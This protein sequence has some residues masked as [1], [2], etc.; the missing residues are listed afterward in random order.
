MTPLDPQKKHQY[1]QNYY[2]KHG[3]VFLS[4]DTANIERELMNYYR[5][6]KQDRNY[7]DEKYWFRQILD[8]W[9]VKHKIP[10]GGDQ[11]MDFTTLLRDP[12]AT[13]AQ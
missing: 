6:A 1:N 10:S 2:L 12:D 5:Q 13:P 11:Q 4:I 9:K 7:E 8:V 3:K